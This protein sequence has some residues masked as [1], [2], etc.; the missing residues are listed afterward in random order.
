M[1]PG[2]RG[3]DDAKEVADEA[4]LEKT[5]ETVRRWAREQGYRPQSELLGQLMTQKLIA[6]STPRTSSPRS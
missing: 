2:R 5:R 4:G 3:K 6:P 1:V